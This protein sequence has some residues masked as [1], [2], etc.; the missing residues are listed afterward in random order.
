MTKRSR[1]R[2]GDHS[3][4]RE[5]NL[6]VILNQLRDHAPISR[7][8]LAEI[9]GLNKTTV[10]SLIQELIDSRYVRETGIDSSGL[11]RPS[12]LLELNPDAGFIVGGEI[13]VDFISAASCNF[14]G[15]VIWQ[16]R[17]QIASPIGQQATLKRTLALLSQAA[18]AGRR[19]YNDH[20]LGVAVGVP[21]LVDQ[22]TGT[23]L[24]APN[25]GWSDVPL[26]EILHGTF[27]APIFVDNE[28]NMA[29]L[30]EHY[31]GAARA[32]EDVLF[33]SAG[34]GLGGAIIRNGHLLR[35]IT[36]FAG[37][38]GHMTFDPDGE[39]CNCGNR[40][41]WE[42]VVS[43]AA[44]LRLIRQEANSAVPTLL[45][46]LTGGHLEQAS[47]PQVV[48]AA[49]AGDDVA[50]RAL[51]MVGHN[52]G[53]G[54]ASLVNALNP[55]L[56][57]LGGI[58]SIA[59]DFLLPAIDIEFKNRALRWNVEATRVVVARYGSEACTMGGIAT[60]VQAILARPILRTLLPTPETLA[61]ARQSAS[62]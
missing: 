57:V 52:L 34:V 29:A 30:A 51:G 32:Y 55:E 35:G 17:E 49:H 47:I 48:E 15:E 40:G 24:F 21:G 27:N 6:S 60:V 46:D 14:G 54:I 3:L 9:T 56:V 53:I 58:L 19:V 22:S 36:G 37:E 28:A 2:T 13:G 10:S 44:V 38:F 42:T 12:V 50:R 25:L 8:T 33:I 59:S 4:V 20:L 1:I 23:L 7:A 5:I 61:P 11:G 16:Y 31:F 18:E 45:R 62:T 39:P 26:R 41:C 43:Q